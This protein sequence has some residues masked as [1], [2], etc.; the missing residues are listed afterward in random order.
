[1]SSL[2]LWLSVR[3]IW[4]LVWTTESGSM[5]SHLEVCIAHNS[6]GLNTSFSWILSTNLDNL[7]T[8]EYTGYFTVTIRCLP[9]RISILKRNETKW[10]DHATRAHM[11]CGASIS[12]SSNRI[13]I[14]NFHPYKKAEKTKQ[15]SDRRQPGCG[16]SARVCCCCLYAVAVSRLQLLL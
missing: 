4:L 5:S 16:P 13:I 3:I 9:I 7:T 11:C 6:Y 10:W 2:P 15:N 12:N 8:Q 14:N 1:M